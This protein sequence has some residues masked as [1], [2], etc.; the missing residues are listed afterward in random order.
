MQGKFD[1]S[2]SRSTSLVGCVANLL[3]RSPPF[4]SLFSEEGK[5]CGALLGNREVHG[6]RFSGH[7]HGLGGRLALFTPGLERVAAGRNVFDLELPLAVGGGE[8][9]RG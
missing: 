5:R 6:G 1:S 3:L 8:V 4:G 9:G 7:G 2:Q